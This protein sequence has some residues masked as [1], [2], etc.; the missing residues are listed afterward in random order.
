MTG[1]DFGRRGFALV[2]ALT[3]VLAAVSGGA[4]VGTVA[5][6][7]P[8]GSGIGID[9]ITGE[10]SNAT[11]P[12]QAQ[13][14]VSGITA[15]IEGE[16]AALGDTIPAQAPVF[17]GDSSA[18]NASTAAADLRQT[19]NS[20]NN[21]STSSS[22]TDWADHLATL[23]VGVNSDRDVV[24][25]HHVHED[26]KETDYLILKHS[27]SEWMSTKMVDNTSRTVDR[28]VTLCEYASKNAATEL[29]AYHEE[30]VVENRT[31]T[32]GY[33]SQME[34]QFGDD[35]SGDFEVLGDADCEG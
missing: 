24:A 8:D 7:S 4:G 35:V 31:P 17:G 10:A 20:H 6:D 2:C 28:D 5:A 33:A 9:I 14:A 26:S 32:V 16:M 12:E 19:W 34:G 1:S 23:G 3:L 13:A 21:E 27:S 22:E 30:F 18:T 29:S 11:L 15:K 25:I